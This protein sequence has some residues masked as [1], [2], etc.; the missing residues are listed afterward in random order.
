[1]LDSPPAIVQEVPP[2]KNPRVA[3]GLTLLVPLGV[4]A[5][6][7]A[8]LYPFT[9]WL[10]PAAALGLGSGHIYAGDP[11]RGILIG[12]GAPV[13]ILGSGAILGGA[14]YNLNL[15]PNYDRNSMG[16][17][18]SLIGVVTATALY[19]GWATVDAYQTTEHINREAKPPAD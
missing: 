12:A 2:P 11:L 19:S 5:G 3:S 16:L 14:T 10:A 8:G 1:M 7:G 18:A 4:V 13:V 15:F 9:Y 6:A 17:A